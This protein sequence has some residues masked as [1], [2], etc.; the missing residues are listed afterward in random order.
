MAAPCEV[1]KLNQE[2]ITY[3]QGCPY[4][5]EDVPVNCRQCRNVCGKESILI[6]GK[7][8]CSRHSYLIRK[9]ILNKDE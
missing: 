7:N 6:A 4:L 2:G 3:W 5:D 9:R 8:I 1:C